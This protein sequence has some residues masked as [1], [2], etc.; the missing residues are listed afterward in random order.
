VLRGCDVQVEQVQER[1][2]EKD[3]LVKPEVLGAREGS[4]VALAEGTFCRREESV[5]V[6]MR[7]DRKGGGTTQEVG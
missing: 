3:K 1:D 5:R 6:P 4:R 2:G 7:R